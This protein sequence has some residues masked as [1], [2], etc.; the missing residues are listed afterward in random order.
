MGSIIL[1]VAGLLIFGSHFLNIYGSA[2]T[3]GLG[4]KGAAMI[5]F[6]VTM[7]IFI[8]FAIVAGDGLLGEIQYI[9]AG[10][11]GFYIVIWLML[12]WIF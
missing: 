10:F 8:V 7:A 5:A 1:G 9:I 2:F 11:G 6:F 4:F 12:A 3:D